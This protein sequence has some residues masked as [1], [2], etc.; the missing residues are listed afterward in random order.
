MCFRWGVEL[1]CEREVRMFLPAL[2]RLGSSSR[3]DFIRV[4]ATSL[5]DSGIRRNDAIVEQ[6]L[7]LQS[8]LP[9]KGGVY[10]A[11]DRSRRGYASVGS[12]I[13][14]CHLRVRPRGSPVEKARYLILTQKAYT[15]PPLRI[16]AQSAK[17]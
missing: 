8:R 16:P 15:A 1:P 10:V 11:D 6:S 17:T 3:N 13:Y 9:L 7:I 14:V 5:L 4:P 2:L 12:D